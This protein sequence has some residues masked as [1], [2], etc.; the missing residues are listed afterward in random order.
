MSQLSAV[1]SA[2]AGGWSDDTEDEVQPIQDKNIHTAS[3]IRLADRQIFIG[4]P[5]GMSCISIDKV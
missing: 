2:W 5:P 3:K 1:I 4:I